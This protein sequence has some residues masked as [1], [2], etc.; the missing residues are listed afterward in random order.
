MT[1]TA[2]ETAPPLYRRFARRNRL[3]AVL[4]VAVPVVG[5]LL[6]CVPLVRLGLSMVA[7]TVS[8]GGVRL[9]R[10]T[11]VIDAPRFTG[12]TGAGE[13]YAM[14]ARTAQTRVG[15]LDTADLADLEVTLTGEGGYR[16][17]ARF[18]SAQWVMSAERLSSN[19]DV[20]VSD[21][22]G[23]DGVLAGVE[24]DW[25]AQIVTSEGPI[26][27]SFSAGGQLRARTMRHDIANATW[28]FSNVSLL[29][30]PTPDAGVSRQP[31][32]DAAP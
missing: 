24:V 1:A 7:E 18:S 6:L 20:F 4:R 23:A 12:T 17:E 19:E 31:I 25:P 22:T 28:Q 9:E 2:F 15:D 10:D 11:L 30:T 8:V 21:T 27:F 13:V 32:T 14:T 5:V 29:M 16:A 26:A 3:V